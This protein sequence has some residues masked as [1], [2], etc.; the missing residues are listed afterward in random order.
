MTRVG[1]DIGGSSIKAVAI[2]PGGEVRCWQSRRYV[3]PDR[4][5]LVD[6]L[7]RVSE[8]LEIQGAEVISAGICLPGI[9]SE[10]GRRIIRSVN[11]P[12]IEGMD[13][14][15]MVEVV[16]P[17]ICGQVIGDALAAAHD[18]R[19]RLRLAGRVAAISIGTGV[20]M[21]VL[22]DAEPIGHT[23]GGAGHLGQVDVRQPGDVP[24]GP[25]GGRGSLEAYIGSEAL[26][27]RFGDDDAA[28]LD[29]L[30]Q[31][32]IPLQA[33]AQA[34]HMVH[35]MYRPATVVLLGGLGFRLA[36]FDLYTTVNRDLTSLAIPSWRLVYGLDDFH[37]ARG[38]AMLSAR[39]V[40]GSADS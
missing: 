34:I 25:D 22:D 33:L 1:L 32:P 5:R 10:D 27:K 12:G 39:P 19:H 14:Q 17:G 6:A 9:R 37:A 15:E 24:I 28:V 35:A 31:D 18:A 16:T 26:R 30:D 13:I 7:R 3:Q 11:V 20:G 38:A 4:S 21:A 40:A 23:D 29:G 2:E 8:A 36:R